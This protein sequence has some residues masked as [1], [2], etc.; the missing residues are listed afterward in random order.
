V[1]PRDLHAVIVDF[2]GQAPADMLVRLR[3]LLG[4]WTPAGGG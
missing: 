4:G 1:K 3:D 2:E